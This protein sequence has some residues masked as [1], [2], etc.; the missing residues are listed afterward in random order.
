MYYERPLAIK[1]LLFPIYSTTTTTRVEQETPLLKSTRTSWL[2]G[3]W[4]RWSPQKLKILVVVTLLIVTTVKMFSTPFGPLLDSSSTATIVPVTLVGNPGLEVK[5][6][7]VSPQPASISGS[8]R[9]GSS[10]KRMSP[11]YTW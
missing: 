11:T 8:A 2:M 1:V 7:K 4:F 9:N 3:N 6:T 10:S 5:R